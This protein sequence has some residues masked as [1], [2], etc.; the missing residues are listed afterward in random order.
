MA[1]VLVVYASDY[2]NTK[3]AA[4]VVAEGAKSVEDTDVVV[5]AAEDVGEADMT[6]ADAVIVGTPVHM[7]S[8]DWRIKKFID[9]V[10]S[11]LWL[12][13]AMKGKVA[14]VFATGGGFGSAGGGVELTLL[15][16]LNNF[17]ELGMFIVPL[18]KSTPG[19]SKGGLQ[20]GPYGRSA[21]ENG[22]PAGVPD[23]SLEAAKH[24]GKHVARAAALL[25]EAK[26]FE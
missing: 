22:E 5:K 3:K 1:R 24:H 17:A 25:R 12:K 14:A 2:G 23:D 11:A 16:L 10:C 21:N 9:T 7:G 20:W 18:P 8:P 19:Y 26:V 15:G 6:S 13:D 4:E